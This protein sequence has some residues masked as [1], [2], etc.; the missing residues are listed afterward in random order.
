M[1]SKSPRSPPSFKVQSPEPKTKTSSRKSSETS[2]PRDVAFPVAKT[3]REATPLP[4]AD[5]AAQGVVTGGNDKTKEF[6]GKRSSSHDQSF[7]VKV[8]VKKKPGRP[9]D[10]GGSF[11]V[12]KAPVKASTLI[13]EGK[14]MSKEQQSNKKQKVLVF[15]EFE[16]IMC[17][18]N[19]MALCM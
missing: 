6:T 2:K 15:S 17:M 14:G 7:K 5:K 8:A 18:P 16:R 9:S 1:P 12:T 10:S 4:G 19:V 3:E 11:S 13:F